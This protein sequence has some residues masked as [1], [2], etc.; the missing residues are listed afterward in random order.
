MKIETIGLLR[1]SVLTPTYYHQ[2]FKT[3]DRIAEHIFQPER[4]ALRL[5]LFSKL[6][7]PS[8]TA[9]SDPDFKAVVL[10]AESLPEDALSALFDLID[11]L[12]NIVLRAVG[13]E[14]HYQLIK[15]GYNALTSPDCTHRIMFRLDD[16]DAVDLDFAVLAAHV[17]SGPYLSYL[18]VR[19]QSSGLHLASDDKF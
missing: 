15:Q 12:P 17:G 10:T 16:D 11:P 8:L 19:N 18:S 3:L 14:E 6:C 4:L 2:K 1:F 9:Q 13:P 5:H 7:L